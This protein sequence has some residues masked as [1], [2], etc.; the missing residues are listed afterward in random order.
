MELL[1][2]C[3]ETMIAGTL[4]LVENAAEVH[5]GRPHSRFVLVGVGAGDKVGDTASGWRCE[6]EMKRLWAGGG[7]QSGK[8]DTHVELWRLENTGRCGRSTSFSREPYRE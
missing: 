2:V 5:H 8:E 7:R 4:C 1:T 3:R 6:G